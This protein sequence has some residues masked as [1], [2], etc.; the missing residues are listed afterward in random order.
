VAPAG[1]GSISTDRHRYRH[2]HTS[3]DPSDRRSFWCCHN[4]FFIRSH[5]LLLAGACQVVNQL[6]QCGVKMIAMRCAGYDRV[7][8]QAC[9]AEG[10]QVTRVPTYSPTSVAEHAVALLFALSRSVHAVHCMAKQSVGCCHAADVW[11][12]AGSSLCS[13]WTL[14]C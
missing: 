2:T 4:C 5:Q 1:W 12:A 9:E 10:I 13:A 14:S 6:K 11:P 3:I 8:L 7:D